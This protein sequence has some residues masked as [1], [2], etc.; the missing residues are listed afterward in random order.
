MI[1]VQRRLF[2]RTLATAAGTLLLGA[3][4]AGPVRAAETVK[5]SE[6]SHLHGIAVDATDPSRLYLASHHGVWLTNP[7]G[8]ATWVSDNRNDYMGFTSNPARPGSF[9]ASGHPER[10]GNLGVL[11]SSDGA[12]TWRQVSAGVNGPVDFHSMDVSAADPNVLYGQYGA[13]RSVGTAERPGRWRAN[14]PLIYSTSRHPGRTRTQSTP[15]PAA[16]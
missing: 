12:R 11:S 15:P 3:A 9:F 16:A 7:D 13:S 10:G 4:L 1:D 14:R 2:V 6:V 5:L 8:T